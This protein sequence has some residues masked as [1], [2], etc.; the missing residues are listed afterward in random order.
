M[1]EGFSGSDI[2]EACRQASVYRMRDLAKANESKAANVPDSESE[3]N[4]TAAELRKITI[5]D[6]LCSVSKLKESKVHCGFIMPNMSSSVGDLDRALAK[7]V[8]K[9]AKTKITFI[10][11]FVK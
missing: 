8:N 6:L 7:R 10:K 1:T 2:R 4:S 3:T 5:D 11:T 9:R